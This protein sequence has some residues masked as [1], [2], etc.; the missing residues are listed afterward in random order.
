MI[1]V[2]ASCIGK[3]KLDSLLAPFFVVLEV[4]M[5]V[6]IPFLM[7]DLIDNGITVGDMAYIEK[8]GLIL[9]LCAL[10]SLGFGALSGFFSARASAG[11]SKNLRKR[12]YDQIQAFSFANIDKFSTP[13]L[14]TRMTTDV[15]NVQQAFTMI[16]RVAV[17]SP[18]MLVL[19]LVCSVR[20]NGALSLVFLAA[21]PILGVGLYFIMT[22][23]HPYFT[24][25][26]KA[27]DHLNTVVQENLRAIRVVKSFVRED[28]ETE[29]FHGTSGEIYDFATHAEKLL[30]LNNP[31]MMFVVYGSM[32]AISW[33]GARFI[34]AGTMTTGELVSMI[35]YTM[36]ILMSLMMLSM[37]FVM[38]VM[39][40]AS[41]IRISE[42]LT[43]VPEL[44]NPA[45]PLET[46]ADGSV[47]FEN[48]SFA[49]AGKGHPYCLKNIDLTIPSGSTVGILG[50]TGSS[51]STLVQLIP[52]LYDATEG[53]VLVGG[54]DVRDYDMEVLRDSVAMVL[55]N[56]ELFS[57]TIKENLRWGDK[58]AADAEL[59]EACVLAEADGFIRSF[60]EG[61]D[62]HIEQGGANVSGGQKQRLCIARALLKKPKILILDD[63]THAVD[64]A[65][66][67]K[68]R[69]SLR[70]CLPETTKIVI[71]QRVASV[72]Q[73][74]FIIVL[75]DGEIVA[76]GDHDTLM[77]TSEAYRE[78]ALSQKK[79]D[80]F[81]AAETR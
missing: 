14:I 7:A 61:Y 24:K 71:A 17:R 30:V 10:L 66:D 77:K 78:T 59:V 6:L 11:F 67:A 2:L 22:G 74:D 8:L 69:A 1:R 16:I 4:V 60:P 3:Y 63:S 73:S 35:T 33:F 40:R 62:T 44:A 27:Y 81:D 13:G 50:S 29:K 47:R 43:E 52:R 72:E 5:E 9:I 39:A 42:V 65:T 64:T 18:I 76:A 28:H 31:L 54:R 58:D 12:I 53:R 48:V 38:I 56:N 23:A 80:D 68:I 79:G 46:V 26:F 21:L 32:L 55:Q 34:V 51:K 36:Q 20:L 25:L 37:I 41:A 70:R 57:G 19:A 49:Y 45:S 15:N 75:E